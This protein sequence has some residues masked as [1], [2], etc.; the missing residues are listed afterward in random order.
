MYV[1]HINYEQQW[2]KNR[3][4]WYTSTNIG[5]AGAYSK[6]VYVFLPAMQINLEPFQTS[7]WYAIILNFVYK[8]MVIQGVKRLTQIYP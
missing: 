3:P 6:K 4:L 2:S 1:V 5:S 8:N 7:V